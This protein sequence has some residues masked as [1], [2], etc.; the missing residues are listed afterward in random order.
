M[1]LFFLDIQMPSI[2]GWD[3]AKIIKNRNKDI[4][5]VISTVHGDYIHDCFDRADWFAVKPITQEKVDKILDYISKKLEPSFI[6]IT[7]DKMVVSLNLS[8]ILFFEKKLNDI[9][10]HT[11]KTTYK[12][13]LS[14]KKL[15][16]TLSKQHNFVQTHKSYIINL[17]YYKLKRGYDI[18]LIDDSIIR[19]SR[20]YIKSFISKIEYYTKEI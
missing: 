15:K 14:L 9:Y 20:T 2:D 8:E 17:D 12:T 4:F 18:Y 6:E 13:R 16:E 5:I 1:I 3:L 10:I 7:I 19:L 11:L